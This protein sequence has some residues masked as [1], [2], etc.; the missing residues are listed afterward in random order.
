M[1]FDGWSYQS[2]YFDP[3]I[4][5]HVGSNSENIEGPLC[6]YMPFSDPVGRVEEGVFKSISEVKMFVPPAEM[7][8]TLHSLKSVDRL[9]LFPGVSI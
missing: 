2:V 7:S 8:Q 5:F 3:S 9:K 6:I 1:P 4:D